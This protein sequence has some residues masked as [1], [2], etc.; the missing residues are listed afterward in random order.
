[1]KESF[2]LQLVWGAETIRVHNLSYDLGPRVAGTDVT[3]RIQASS[4][5]S[6]TDC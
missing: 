1:M 6:V 3:M 5:Q 4:V 2:Q